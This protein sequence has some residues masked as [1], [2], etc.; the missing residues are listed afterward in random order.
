MEAVGGDLYWKSYKVETE[1]GY[2]LRM[3]RII[4]RGSDNESVER[5][6]DQ[7]S[8]GPLLLMHGH[9]SDGVHWLS[10]NLTDANELA[11]PSQLF[12]EGYDVWLG[13]ARGTMYSREHISLDPDEDEREYWNF[14]FAENGRDDL[15]AM[16]E[17]IHGNPDPENPCMKITYVGHS[18]G[19]M[20]AFYGLAKAPYAY[21]Y[22]G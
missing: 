20:S 16:I 18:A 15:P 19:T 4:G 21:K 8:L 5:I 3:F 17:T 6:E 14:S 11:M 9:F 1:D 12:L 22:I 7:G 10:N 13:N 2:I